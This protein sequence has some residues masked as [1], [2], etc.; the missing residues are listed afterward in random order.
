MVLTEIECGFINLFR[1]HCLNGINSALVAVTCA[2]K[3]SKAFL[4]AVGDGPGGRGGGGGRM[5][6]GS[7]LL[8]LEGGIL[9][10]EV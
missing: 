8:I 5:R 6:K 1:V 4:A 2:C 9:I 3:L 7:S 10:L